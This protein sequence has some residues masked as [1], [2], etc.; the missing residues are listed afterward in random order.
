MPLIAGGA[1]I[2]ANDLAAEKLTASK[3]F[4][5]VTITATAEKASEIQA[6][7]DPYEADDGEVFNMRIKLGGAGKP[8]YRS[9]KFDADKGETVTVYLNSSSKTDARICMLT[10]STGAEIAEITAPASP[11]A[12][13]F[14]AGMGTFKIPADGTYY[15][16]SKASGIYIY[17]VEAE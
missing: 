12:A 6:L 15:L 9:I 14:K 10:D 3:D 5:G 7:T 13:P 1:F 11:A 8:E 2:S 4:D 17:M 16:M